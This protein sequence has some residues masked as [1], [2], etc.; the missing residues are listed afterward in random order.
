[1]LRSSGL[2]RPG[3]RRAT[4]QVRVVRYF[5]SLIRPAVASW[6]YKTARL[7]VSRCSRIDSW[8]MLVNANGKFCADHKCRLGRIQVHDVSASRQ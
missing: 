4:I 6:A 2:L 1:M 5:P 7:R 3:G 8:E